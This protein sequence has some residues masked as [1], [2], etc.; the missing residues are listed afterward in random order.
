MKNFI[1]STAATLALC[2]LLQ[3]FLPWWIIAIVA[4]AVAF[5]VPQKPGL[6]FLSGFVAVFVL[7]VTYAYLLSSA[8]NHLLAEKVAVLMTDLTKNSVRMLHLITGLVGGLVA[9]FAALSGAL[10]VKLIK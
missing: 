2:G 7:W 1:L 3:L 9:G 10:L 5:F 6:A 4:G 8:N